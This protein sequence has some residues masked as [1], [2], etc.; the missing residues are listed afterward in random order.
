V[1]EV[2]TRIWEDLFG[3]LHGPLVLRLISQ[4]SVACFLAVRAGLRDARAG[5]PAFGWAVFTR[6]DHRRDLL[7]QG[8]KDVGRLFLI[9]MTLD[10]IYQLVVIRWVYPGE[11]LLV[12]AILALLPYFLVRGPVN[13]LASIRVKRREDTG[14]KTA[15]P[16]PG[17][18]P[19][20]HDRRQ[21]SSDSP[22]D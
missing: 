5:R 16:A 2:L 20:P 6:P 11:T 15:V 8:W 14:A 13:R 18:G 12:A 10:V 9:A 19:E 3:R 4:P 22:V 7:R 1:E 21:A 17:H